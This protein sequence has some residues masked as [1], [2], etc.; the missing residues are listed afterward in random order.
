MTS[1]VF[2]EARSDAQ[3][4]HH[5]HSQPGCREFDREWKPVNSF[6]DFFDLHPV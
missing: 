4:L 1:R 5:K 2:C 6:Y 3:V